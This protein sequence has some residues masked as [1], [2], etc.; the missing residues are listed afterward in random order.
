MG[1]SVPVAGDG[2]QTNTLKMRTV[3]M[4]AKPPQWR[5]FSLMGVPSTS[6]SFARKSFVVN[7]WFSVLIWETL[8]GPN[9]WANSHARYH[10]SPPIDYG[11]VH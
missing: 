7:H 1:R 4:D 11:E 9:Y 3:Y 5:D 8:T 10:A 2:E 6:W